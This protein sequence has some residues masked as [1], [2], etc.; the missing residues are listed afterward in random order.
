MNT[1]FKQSTNVNEKKHSYKRLFR[2]LLFWVISMSMTNN[3]TASTINWYQKRVSNVLSSDVR[4]VNNLLREM[5]K[6]PLL[7]PSK[8]I[9]SKNKSAK[10]III[11]EDVHWYNE[12]EY[13]RLQILKQEF[14]INLV[15]LEWWAGHKADKIRWGVL[16]NG[17]EKLI[18]TSF[19]DKSFTLVWLE[20]KIIQELSFLYIISYYI[21]KE[22]Y[23]NA[24]NFWYSNYDTID[25]E[26]TRHMK[27]MWLTNTLE[28]QTTVNIMIKQYMHIASIA[29]NRMY[30][31]QD[32]ILKERNKIWAQKMV[33][34]L[35]SK[36]D[37]VWVLFFGKNHT[38]WLINSINRLWDF[39]II[40]LSQSK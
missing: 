13:D 23:I 34:A 11:I 14:G 22:K 6:I 10:T 5:K 17:E 36:K 19:Q 1:L 16:L 7:K 25:T 26:L 4:D 35:H 39:N 21:E 15:W 30:T 3:A 18:K 20:N 2:T 24:S 33:S 37:K 40:V 12:S 31:W 27:K 9:L 32:L 29:Y 38:N 28:N 8:T